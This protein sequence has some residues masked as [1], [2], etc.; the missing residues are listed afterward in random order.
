MKKRFLNITLLS[1]II[2]GFFS[3][4]NVSNVQAATLYYNAG[5]DTNWNTLANWWTDAGFTA[6]AGSLPT[7]SDDVVIAGNVVSV[8]GPAASVN[9]MIV[10]SSFFT[11]IP[12]TVANGAT[13][14]SSSY[15]DIHGNISGNVTFNSSSYNNGGTVSGNAVFNNFSVNRG[16]ISGDAIFNNSSYNYD[17]V[18]GNAIFSYASG[19]TITLNGTQAWGNVAGTVK[20]NDNVLITEFIFND[21]S[22][23]NAAT[24]PGNATFNN[25]SYNDGGSVSGNAVF[26]DSST[27]RFGSSVSGN[28]IFNDSSSNNNAA[29]IFGDASFYGSSNNGNGGVVSGNATFNDSSYNNGIV[30]TNAS[31]YD[32]TTNGGTVTGN[33]CFAL[34]ADQDGGTVGGVVTTCAAFIPTVT[35]DSSTV[36]TP[37]SA[38]LVGTITDTGQESP[39]EAGFQYGL[40]TSYGSYISD[41]SGVYVRQ[42]FNNTVTGLVSCKT[43]HYRAFA[44]GATAGIGFGTDRTFNTTGCSSGGGGRTPPPTT[45]NPPQ[46]LV[47]N[48]CTTPPPPTCTYPQVLVNG[49]CV[50]PPPTCTSPQVLVN[51]VCTT[52]PPP[53]PTCTPPQVL[54]N[55]VCT[56]PTPP[57]TC[58]S[59]QVLRNGVCVTPKPKPVPVPI[60]PPAPTPPPTGG[61][62][63]GG[64]TTPPTTTSENNVLGSVLGAAREFTNKPAVKLVANVAMIVP[65]AASL[66]VLGAALLAGLPVANY[67]FYL[68]VVF[69]QILGFS[70]KPKP[71]G[72]VYDSHTKKPLPFA[73][74]EILNEQSRK[75]QST[76]TDADGRYGFLISDQIQKIQFQAHLTKYDFPAQEEPSVVEQKLFPNI[77]K[78]GLVD[79]VGGQAN[80]DL[81]MH[82]RE[83]ALVPAFYFGITSVKLNNLLS[84]AA[85][86]LFVIGSAFGI[87]NAIVNPSVASYSILALIFLTFLIRISGFK[88]KPFGLT[89]DTH[90]NKT[91]PFGLIT[92][93][94]QQ[95][96]RT[97][98]TVSDDQGRYFLLTPK[99]N[100]TL[101]AFTPSHIS[102]TRTKEISIST[103]RGWVSREVVV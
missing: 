81:P 59:P 50:T 56:N 25:S 31:F 24:L 94:N 36:L 66:I 44:V 37:S 86:V 72:T 2:I 11:D 85:N 26:N 87:A 90:T 82:P 49:A 40:T 70:K 21:T 32:S 74:V 19:G 5:T 76:V 57:P 13:F 22:R 71:W 23:I 34:T 77:Y 98:F 92:L 60:T 95:G 28:A 47:N 80:Y 69:S 79:V 33:A 65:I 78:G 54:R 101:K 4:I 68:F 39:V 45:C 64:T 35:T 43:Y 3:L 53:P 67:L 48:I 9:T 88:L 7:I 41:G 97:N 42:T 16:T 18:S 103:R 61:T 100:Y 55:G 102:P 62:T 52:P 93:H 17:T 6:P 84:G 30:S 27:N 89:K 20:G 51:G 91:L 75:L 10:N 15:N 8:I 38:N 96:E 83:K 46:V 73:R 63:T 14:N 12:I 58:I 29:T 1:F 99:G